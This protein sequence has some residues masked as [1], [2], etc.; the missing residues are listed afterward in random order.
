[1]RDGSNVMI[2]F[3]LALKLAFIVTRQQLNIPLLSSF[4][5]PRYV[6]R[7]LF[8]FL[9]PTIPHKSAGGTVS[10][11]PIG[12]QILIEWSVPDITK[13]RSLGHFTCSC[14]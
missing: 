12:S 8:N 6:I 13:V 9:L 4:S 10:M 2:A 7:K 1:M 14:C 5:T 11:S 3:T